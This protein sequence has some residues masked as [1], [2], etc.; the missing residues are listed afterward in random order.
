MRVPAWVKGTSLLIFAFA[1]GI[2]FGAGYEQS[3]VE[4]HH[5]TTMQTHD[6]LDHLTRELDL[7]STQRT[8]IASIL[9]RHQGSVD[10]AWNA[11]QPHMRDAMHLAL[12]EITG[13]LRPDQLAKYR[14]M[15]GGRHTEAFH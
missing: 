4:R 11:V 10:S 3:R 12:Q 9:T 15:M 7:D 8:A 13:V 6:V 1:A 5:A 2:V 14:R